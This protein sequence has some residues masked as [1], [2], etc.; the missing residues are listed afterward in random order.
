[1]IELNS[2]Y[3]YLVKGD[4]RDRKVNKA[5]AKIFSVW[6][7]KVVKYLTPHYVP[8]LLSPG[9]KCIGIEALQK[10]RSPENI[11]MHSKH[12]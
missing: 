12:R 4:F 1:M 3:M 11:L 5:S 10:P 2:C 7:E 9:I 8:L 6:K